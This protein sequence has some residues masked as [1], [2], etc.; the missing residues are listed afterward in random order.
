MSSSQQWRLSRYVKQDGSE[1]FSKWLN[2]LDVSVQRRIRVGLARLEAGN[3][4]SI[5]WLGGNLGEFRMD[6]G[7]G[8]RIYLTKFGDEIVLLIGGDKQSQPKDIGQAREFVTVL[9]AKG[10]KGRLMKRISRPPRK[11]A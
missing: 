3:F 7:P 8:Y 1:P 11:K 10:F 9:K 2:K 5:K 4:S 6:F